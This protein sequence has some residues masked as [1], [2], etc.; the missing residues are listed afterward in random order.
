[1]NEALRRFRPAI[2]FILTFLAGCLFTG[3]FFNR[4]ESGAIGRLDKLYVKQYARA[5]E[6][7]GRL[8]TELERERR[9]NCQLRDHNTRARE[10]ACELEGA[11]ERN[12]RNLQDAIAI[13]VEVRAKL[14]I[15]EDFFDNSDPGNSAN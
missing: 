14:K 13:I 1:L 10:L 6:T 2:Y 3:F 9:L 8:E 5:T 12:V 4:S 11:T 7:I 15:L